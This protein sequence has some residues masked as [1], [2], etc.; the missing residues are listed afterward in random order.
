MR[1]KIPSSNIHESQKH[2]IQGDRIPMNRYALFF[3]PCLIGLGLDLWTKHITFKTYFDPYAPQQP[4]WW[5]DGILGIQTSTNP[6]ALFGIGSG[7]STVFAAFSIVALTGILAW[8][9]LFKGAHD[10]W[11]TFALGLVS[12]GILGNFYDRI[13]WG[14]DP[15]WPEIISGNVR[16]WIHFRLQGVPFFD[17]WPNF[18]IADS[19]LVCGAA[20]L[21][22]HAFLFYEPDS[23]SDNQPNL[24]P[25]SEPNPDSDGAET[26]P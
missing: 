5:I 8:M 3:L 6:G 20:L 16:D 26:S 11:L 10:R 24:S 4:L 19:A 21:M 15:T 23:E 7:L 22:I 13:G 12:G 25:E 14:H 2:L 18:N 1:S 9:F 17:P